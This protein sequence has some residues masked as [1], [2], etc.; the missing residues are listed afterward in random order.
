MFDQRFLHDQLRPFMAV[1]DGR[2]GVSNHFGTG[3]MHQFALWCWIR[4]LQ[5]RYIIESGVKRGL[6]TWLLRQAAPQAKLV[7]LDPINRFIYRDEKYDTVYLTGDNFTDFA[8]VDWTSLV[9]PA[10]TLVFIDDHNYPIRRIVEANRHGFKHVI[11]DDNYWLGQG[12]MTTLKLLCQM[13]LGHMTLH[14]MTYKD[15]GKKTQRPMTQQDLQ[16]ARDVFDD[17]IEQYYEF[18]MIWNSSEVITNPGNRNFMFD[19]SKGFDL[20]RRFGL[21]N[22]PPPTE[23]NGYYNIVYV[24][25]K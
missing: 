21:V 23:I 5:P 25:L 17:V 7:L 13:L 22:V 11:F 9:D 16:V 4:K 19:D 6:A 20:L 18:P 3:I 24:K 10:Q 2:P 15:V 12:D 1:Y 14:R 8:H